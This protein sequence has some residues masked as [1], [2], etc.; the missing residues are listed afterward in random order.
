MCG[1]LFANVHYCQNP[2]AGDVYCLALLPGCVLLRHLFGPFET[3]TTAAPQLTGSARSS[4]HKKMYRCKKQNLTDVKYH[5][6]MML[7]AAVL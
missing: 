6:F 7:N 5:E 4:M 1:N 2:A 3:M